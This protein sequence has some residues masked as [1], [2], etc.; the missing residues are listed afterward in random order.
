MPAISGTLA[1][2]AISGATTYVKSDEENPSQ[3]K[4]GDDYSFGFYTYG[5]FAASY[6]VEGIPEGLSF[7]GSA[8]GPSY[9]ALLQMQDLTRLRLLATDIP[10]Q[11]GSTKHQHIHLIWKSSLQI[12]LGVM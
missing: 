2:H 1:T 11:M 6:K 12:R 7:N 4:V 9:Q 3:A 10:A 5:H 8:L